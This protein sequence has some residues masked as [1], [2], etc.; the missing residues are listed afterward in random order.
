[1]T[2]KRNPVLP[3][4]TI[5]L[6]T[7]NPALA[8]Y[9]SRVRKD[10]RYVSLSVECQKASSLED[11]VKV[12]AKRRVAG[13]YDSAWA[14]FCFKDFNL[15][16]EEVKA[17][18]PVAEAKK[19]KLGWLNPSLSMWLFLHTKPINAYVSNAASFDQA[20]GKVFPG[21][22]ETEE[23][24]SNDGKDI[25]LRLFSLFSKAIVNASDYNKL[26]EKTT[27]LAATS[28]PLLYEDIKAIC[29]EA[30]LSHNQRLLSK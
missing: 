5:L 22:A 19:V 25:H 16:A 17:V 14:V 3:K 30:D 20:L 15:K 9:F 24:M 29:G 26:C 7:S 8:V 10:C 18:E 12:T 27:G 21:Y 11:L 6:V 2:R 4:K 1:M 23:Y 28:F 13:K